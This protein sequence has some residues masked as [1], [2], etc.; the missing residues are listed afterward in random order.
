MAKK[1][2]AAKKKVGKKK[3]RKKKPGKKKSGKK[4]SGKKK[5]GKKKSGK[6]KSGKKN[7]GKNKPSKK[8]SG[9]KKS[10]KKKPSKKKAS[11]K[12]ASKR[13]SKKAGSRSVKLAVVVANQTDGT[14]SGIVYSKHKIKNVR[15]GVIELA[16]VT[17]YQGVTHFVPVAPN[18]YAFEFKNRLTPYPECNGVK[19]TSN[20]TVDEVIVTVVFSDDLEKATKTTDIV[21]IP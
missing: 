4:K 20:P 12:R 17:R 15:C 10:G 13:S 5:P 9:K 6:K 14:T 16:G 3:A 19:Y 2:K 11:K 18:T 21:V 8:K 1:K 7:S